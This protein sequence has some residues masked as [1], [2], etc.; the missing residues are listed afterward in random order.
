MHRLTNQP[1]LT[2]Q[3]TKSKAYRI[4]FMSSKERSWK[5][6][7]K[8]YYLLP[9]QL[10]LLNLISCNVLMIS[11]QGRYSLLIIMDLP[12]LTIIWIILFLPPFLITITTWPPPLTTSLITNNTLGT[13]SNPYSTSLSVPI[14]NSVDDNGNNNNN[15]PKQ[16]QSWSSPNVVLNICGDIAHLSVCSL[17]K[18]CLFTNICF[19][20]DKY[21]IEVLSAQISSDDNRSYYLIQAKVSYKIHPI[22]DFNFLW[23]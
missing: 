10:T 11:H 1:W 20:L 13:S 15:N 2:K 4:L 3:W 21:K 22:D 19:V 9:L 14:V 7:N 23:K 12:Y 16:F 8:C 18:R 6:S 17:K 5:G